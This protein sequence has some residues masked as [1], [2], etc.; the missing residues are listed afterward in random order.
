MNVLL[1]GSGG[2][3]HAFAWKIAQ[4][5][6]L[7]TLYIAPGNAGSALV[8][9]NLSFS[10]ND[11]AAIKQAIL[12]YS[13]S[14]VIV[15]PEEPLVKG[16]HDF[17]ASDAELAHVKVLGPKKLGATLE[18]SK[19]FAK[20]FMT[21]HAIPTAAHKTITAENLQEGFEFLAQQKPPYVLKADGLAAGKG[22][23]IIDNLPEAQ[24]ELQ[25]MLHGKFGEA[26]KKVVIE[27]CLHG[28]EMSIF[29]ITDGT[30]YIV[31]P[32]AKDY[33]R[34][35]EADTGLNTGG[36]GAVS[37]VPFCTPELLAHIEQDIIKPTVEG[38]KKDAI[39]YCGFLFFG[40]MVS[41]SQ[42]KVI[43]YNVRMGDPETE[44]V[45]PRIES[46]FLEL[47]Y[48]AAHGE[49]HKTA[50]RIAPDYA[51]TVMIVSGGYPEAYQQDKR[52][53]LPAQSESLLFHAGTKLTDKGV[54]TQGGRVLAVT[55]LDSTMHKAL[56]KSYNSIQHISFENMYY[57][58]DIGFDL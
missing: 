20:E 32:E 6:L 35:G 57:R 9:T 53:T 12:E 40:L 17:I 5:P 15:G 34:I 50:V 45:I 56:E 43:E 30:N 13:I 33:K 31:L 58:K 1:L 4:S 25:N 49:L 19:E 42:A 37:P 14:L 8:G 55:S 27:E 24:E 29:A 36:M 23:L 38:L 21:R 10:A 52:I 47:C 18:G 28:I 16:V 2:R 48:A 41:G 3:E 44:V 46:D 39:D 26:S 51:T 54:V 22:V 7:K 11:T